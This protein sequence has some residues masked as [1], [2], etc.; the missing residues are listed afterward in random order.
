MVQPHPTNPGAVLFDDDAALAFNDNCPAII[1]IS[2]N[3]R[4]NILTEPERGHDCPCRCEHPTLGEILT[5][6]LRFTSEWQ[7][8]SNT[9]CD[10]V[11][12]AMLLDGCHM[13]IKGS[14]KLRLWDCPDNNNNALG[15]RD[16]MH[17]GC[18]E[19]KFVMY[20]PV[21]PSDPSAGSIPVFS[22][23][24]TGVV[25]LDPAPCPGNNLPRCCQ[26][27]HVHG[28]LTGHGVGPMEDCTI[29]AAY[30]GHFVSIEGRD[31]CVP[32]DTRWDVT[33][34]GVVCCPCPDGDE[35]GDE[36]KK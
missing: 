3:I 7:L 9:E 31:L 19:A 32:Q 12:T 27:N 14:L 2:K 21:D 33:L 16:D 25:G 8:T 23:E 22:G 34:D 11:K 15:E 10:H 29:C 1:P 17:I 28:M 13:T 5:F 18:Q 36:K 6:P 26:P 35:K 30:D 24:L 20:R 4:S